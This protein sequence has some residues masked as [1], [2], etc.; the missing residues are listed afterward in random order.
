M[1]VT[2]NLGLTTFNTASGSSIKFQEFRLALADES[3]NMSIIDTAYATLGNS[4]S[5]IRGTANYTV[6]ANYVSPGYYNGTV[7]LLE[8]YTTGMLLTVKLSVTNISPSI[9][10]INS[11][12]SLLLKKNDETGALVDIPAGFLI[13]GKYYNFIFDGSYLIM[14]NSA[15]ASSDQILMSGSAN[16]FVSISASSTLIDSGVPILLG[17]VSGSYN[18]VDVDSYGRV[19][20]GSLVTSG[21]TI[22]Y[23]STPY[24]TRSNLTF[25][26]GGIYIYDDSGNDQTVIWIS[27][28]QSRLYGTD[29]GSYTGWINQE[30][31]TITSIDD[32]GGGLYLSTPGV[33]TGISGVYKTMPTSP[34]QIITAVSLLTIDNTGDTKLFMGWRNASS[35]ALTG[36]TIASDAEVD[37]QKWSDESTNDGSYITPI[38]NSRFGNGGIIWIKLYLN[39]TTDRT[40]SLSYDGRVWTDLYTTAWDDYLTPNDFAFGII[41]TSAIESKCIMYSY[42]EQ[43]V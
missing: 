11:L 15:I 5:A 41:S 34:Y 12:G 33:V 39:D 43:S 16:N 35:G 2:P 36:I 7:P 24:A 1:T 30:S 27:S 13:A 37:V 17:V 3:S 20:S 31:T 38:A 42:F 8:I 4:I 22:K 26:G 40:I 28:T 25:T 6:I 32:G 18:M 10:N 23:N 21:H 14:V 29:V 19:T 9:L